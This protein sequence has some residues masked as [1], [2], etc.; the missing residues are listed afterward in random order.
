MST[1]NRVAARQASVVFLIVNG[2]SGPWP[3]FVACGPVLKGTKPT[4]LRVEQPR[5]F[6]FVINF[7]T[8]QALG[9]TIPEHVLLQATEVI[10]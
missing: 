6:E 5:E 2:S 3:R 8:A 9:L 7:K 4:D 10:Q 1:V